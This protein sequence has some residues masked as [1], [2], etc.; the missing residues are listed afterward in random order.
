MEKATGFGNAAPHKP[1]KTMATMDADM[2]IHNE[3]PREAVEADVS[4]GS[5][6]DLGKSTAHAARA[7][8]GLPQNLGKRSAFPTRHF[9]NA[10]AFS[11]APTSLQLLSFTK[12]RGL[13]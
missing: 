13:S 10:F 9:E 6:E 8:L 12:T 3:D 11:T 2:R 1:A 4:A 7:G 5:V